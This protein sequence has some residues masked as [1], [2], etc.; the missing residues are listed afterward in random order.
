MR[1][2]LKSF[3]AGRDCHART[4]NVV[5]DKLPPGT[6]SEAFTNRKKLLKEP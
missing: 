3:P 4:K 5:C 6:G 1:A 2:S